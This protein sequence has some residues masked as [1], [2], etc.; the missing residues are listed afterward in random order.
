MYLTVAMDAGVPIGPENL[1]NWPDVPANDFLLELDTTDDLLDVGSHVAL[2]PANGACAVEDA[3][4]AA[5]LRRATAHHA[6]ITLKNAAEVS[7]FRA[8]AT[9]GSLQIRALGY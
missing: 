9:K 3:T 6:L 7:T 4:V 5:V 1:A 8:A 2:C